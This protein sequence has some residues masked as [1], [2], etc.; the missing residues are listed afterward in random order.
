[1]NVVNFY[2]EVFFQSFGLKRAFETSEKPL[3]L[4]RSLKAQFDSIWFK[5]SDGYLNYKKF[6]NNEGG[7]K[8]RGWKEAFIFL[9]R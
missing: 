4:C 2:F 5:K 7:K 8:Q 6:R 9:G 3:V 1:M